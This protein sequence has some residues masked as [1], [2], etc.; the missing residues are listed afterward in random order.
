VCH[1]YFVC[2]YMAQTGRP[3]QR[4]LI[5]GKIPFLPSNN[6]EGLPLLH[7]CW[8]L[9]LPGKKSEQEREI[10]QIRHRPGALCVQRQCHFVEL[11]VEQNSSFIT[12]RGARS[13][14]LGINE[15]AHTRIIT[16]SNNNSH[17]FLN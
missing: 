15:R 14:H 16:W 13:A 2:M 4:L 11:A 12:H 5:A 8:L 9:I 3:L 10:H 7:G 1:V 17:L 6:K